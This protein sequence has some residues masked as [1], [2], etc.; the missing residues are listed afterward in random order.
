MSVVLYSWWVHQNKLVLCS[1][2]IRK[3][4]G[5]KFLEDILI[6]IRNYRTQGV[7]NIISIGTDKA[8]K[9]IKS[10]LEDKPYR[11]VLTTCDTDQHVKIT[12]RMIRFV[13]ERIGVVRLAIP[14]KIIPK[15]L[16]IE[17]VH[18]VIILTNLLPCKADLHSSVLIPREIVA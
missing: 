3:K 8:F 16:P 12:E 14:Y 4:Y 10:E 2:F 11:V 17:M 6:M 15:R 13:K 7:F 9:L 5:D 18:C 1:V